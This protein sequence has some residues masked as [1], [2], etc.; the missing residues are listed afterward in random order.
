MPAAVLQCEAVDERLGNRLYRERLQRVADFINVARC[1]DQAN[2]E[3]FWIGFGKLRDVG[4][5]VALAHSG[6]LVVKVIEVVGNGRGTGAS[7]CSWLA[8]E[9]VAPGGKSDSHKE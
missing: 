4:C 1:R 2:A 6:E 3:P 8:F 5:N 9:V 7:N